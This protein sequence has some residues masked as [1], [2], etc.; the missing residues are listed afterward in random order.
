M[1]IDQV[2]G[3]ALEK[4]PDERYQQVEELLEDLRSISEG[5][6]PEGIKARIRKAKLRRRKRAILYAGTAG[7]LII[8]TVVT[9][10]L[11]TGRAE[12]L[13]SIA[14]LPLENLSGD[15]EQDY[16]AAGVHEALITDLYNLSGLKR[17]IARPSVMRY[18]NTALSPREIARELNVSTL[19]TG[20]VLREGDKVRVT[21]Q[22]VKAETEENMW[23]SRFERELQDMLALQNEIVTQI[24]KEIEVTLTPQEKARLARSLQINPEAQEAYLK[25]RH[26]LYE[27]F[28]P[29]SKQHAVEYLERAIT[30]DPGYAQAYATLAVAYITMSNSIPPDRTKERQE[31][32]RK[33]RIAAETALELDEGLSDGY[34][35]LAYAHALDWDWAGA[36]RLLERALEVGP[37][38][39]WAH[40]AY[41]NFLSNRGMHEEAIKEAMRA[42]ELDPLIPGMHMGVATV[43][44]RARRYDEAIEKLQNILEIWPN[45]PNAW[46]QLAYNYLALGQKERAVELWQKQ[47]EL[48][49]NKDLAEAYKTLNF[50]RAMRKWVEQATGPSPQIAGESVG[51]A[52]VYSMIGEK[53]E[54]L[55]WLE[56]A[57]RERSIGLNSLATWFVWD[58]LRDD[59]RFQDLLDRIGI[60]KKPNS[61]R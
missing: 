9:L 31:A 53:E 32:L 18:K 43:L 39:A 23:A 56:R 20:S 34:R 61:E 52:H 19:L 15:P 45:N 36:E 46:S 50:E 7:F 16:I 41:S 54:A 14:V 26:L 58:P 37:N 13:D 47:N 60:W 59:P 8:M 5:I 29:Q 10:S 42:L 6:E 28:N 49:G 27:Q 3:K 51:I 40:T 11:F 25:G 30:A 12:G 24:A 44:N 48:R 21:A 35:M 1:A 17:V 38:N 4:N 22:L 2:V 55:A 33:F 57:Y